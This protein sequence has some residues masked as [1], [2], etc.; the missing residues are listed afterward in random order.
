M[1]HGIEGYFAER[2]RSARR[3]AMIAAC[4][5][6]ALLGL[7]LATQIAFVRHP[8]RDLLRRSVRFG[9]EG[10]DQYV[11]RI[12]LQQ[13]AG[14]GPVLRN[15][16]AVDARH[17]R[18][19]GA[20]RTR[21]R[22]EPLAPPEPHAIVIGPGLSDRDLVARA[23]SRLANVPVVQSQDLVIEHSALPIYPQEQSDHGVEGKVMVQ[24]LVDTAGR[25]VDVQLLASSGVAPFERSAQEAVWQYRFRPYRSL[26]S[27]SEVYAIFRFAFRVY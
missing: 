5:G 17:S 19:G 3:I 10:P 22:L 9:F 16:G 18:R 14:S 6:G 27:A 25:V 8:M 15:V 24:A 13:L 11:R 2:A 21:A 20:A 12:T 4:L 1:N 23:V 26:G 7:I